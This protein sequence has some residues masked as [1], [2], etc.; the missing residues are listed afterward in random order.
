MKKICA[1]LFAL[2]LM[3]SGAYADGIS[4]VIDG[5]KAEFAEAPYIDDGYT[6]VPMRGIFEKLGADIS[7]NDETKTV[8]ATFADTKISLAINSD[9]IKTVRE[10]I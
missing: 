5:E 7:W 3:S 9:T 1:I 8:G 10:Y 6:F 2:T 4:V